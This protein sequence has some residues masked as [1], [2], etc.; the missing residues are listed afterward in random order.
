MSRIL[1]IAT[2]LPVKSIKRKANYLFKPPAWVSLDDRFLSCGENKRWSSAAAQ[3]I[4]H[5]HDH[6]HQL[7]SSVTVLSFPSSS[8][9]SYIP[10]LSSQWTT[11]ALVSMMMLVDVR[12]VKVARLVTFR[13]IDRHVVMLLGSCTC[14]RQLLL[15]AATTISP[16]RSS[17][18]VLTFLH[19]RSAG[20]RHNQVGA[21]S[22]EMPFNLISYQNA[23]DKSFNWGT[24]RWVSFSEQVKL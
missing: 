18:N 13:C 21:H 8:R 14:L 22:K 11:Y 9:V 17:W 23:A 6:Q 5:D 24:T 4:E 15:F 20:R 3:N 1:K 16:A 12:Q 7:S 19:P 2:Y 10:N